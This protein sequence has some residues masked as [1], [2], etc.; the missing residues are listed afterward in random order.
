MEEFAYH[1]VEELGLGEHVGWERGVRG[2]LDGK[3]L[4]GGWVEGEVLGE[5]MTY[6]KKSE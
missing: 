6:W 4:E 3:G 1:C 2:G 5:E